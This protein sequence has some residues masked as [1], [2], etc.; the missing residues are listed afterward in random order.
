MC[1]FCLFLRAWCAA[2]VGGG[3]AGGLLACLKL[4]VVPSSSLA[5]VHFAGIFYV[6]PRAATRR[7]VPTGGQPRRPGTRK[8]PRWL[9]RLF[10][11]S[12][13]AMQSRFVAWS[14]LGWC[15]QNANP[16][17]LREAGKAAAGDSGPLSGAPPWLQALNGRR[18]LLANGMPADLPRR[19]ILATSQSDRKA[20]RI[21]R[22]SPGQSTRYLAPRQ[23]HNHEARAWL[24][25]A[26]TRSHSLPGGP[27]SL[28][29]AHRPQK[30]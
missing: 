1:V 8:Y 24:T 10:T 16:E 21:R 25:G 28:P 22:M 7:S 30:K 2:R 9:F 13:A 14:E 15:W 29:V 20:R 11:V 3:V 4:E 18:L 5:E 26:A 17:R 19:K 27:K 12:C 23:R 6:T